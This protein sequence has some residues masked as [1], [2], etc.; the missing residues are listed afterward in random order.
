MACL[1]RFLAGV[2]FFSKIPDSLK[3][4]LTWYVLSLQHALN[5]NSLHRC[6]TSF[7]L[8]VIS[9]RLDTGCKAKFL[10]SS[11]MF[12][13]VL[14]DPQLPKPLLDLILPSC[15][16][17]MGTL[18]GILIMPVNGDSPYLCCSPMEH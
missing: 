9:S 8:N 15:R 14:K 5:I 6:G 13:V 17:L 12:S 16:L 4:Q 7:R 18:P 11:P 2:E 1:H 3:L 10:A